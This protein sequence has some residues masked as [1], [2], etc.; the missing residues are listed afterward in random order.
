[1][2]A[3]ACFGLPLP[4]PSGGEAGDAG[5]PDLHDPGAGAPAGEGTSG[6]Y[7]EGGASAAATFD[8]GAVDG[9]AVDAAADV[10]LVP[11][12]DASPEA[13]VA[14]AGELPEAGDASPGACS[15]QVP[16]GSACNAIV[17]VGPSVTPTCATGTI[18]VGTGGTLVDGTYVRTAQTYYNCVSGQT[19]P[20]T[21]VTFVVA[22]SCVQVVVTEGSV[23]GTISFAAAVQGNQLTPTATCGNPAGNVTSPGTFTTDGTTL[24]LY[25]PNAATPSVDV[26]TRVQ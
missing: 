18:P 20:A 13:A 9:G 22:G 26:F 4:I 17:N 21:N 15:A 12:H 25:S 1:M 16:A 5:G 10:G 8:A 23:T 2:T 19:F 3:T 6:G 14:D 24:T 7:A 11:V